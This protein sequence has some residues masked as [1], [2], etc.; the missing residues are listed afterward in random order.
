MMDV[1]LLGCG[2][3]MPL[4]DRFLTSCMVQVNGHSI[5]IDCGE[6]TQTAIRCAGLSFKPIDM[7]CITHF[8]A[9]H[10]AGLIGVLLSMAN[11]ERTDPVTI[12]TPPKGAQ[13]LPHLLVV[14][15][16]LPFDLYVSELKSGIQHL[17]GPDLDITAF[18]DRKSVV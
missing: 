18:E 5:L 6:S 17:T 16:K 14:A 13:I 11:S 10:L 2:G 12:V 4:P 3:M 15:P 9:D 7:I 1:T 8:H